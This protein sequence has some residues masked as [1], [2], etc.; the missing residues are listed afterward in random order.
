MKYGNHQKVENG[1][2]RKLPGYGFRWMSRFLK[3][4]LVAKDSPLV[5]GLSTAFTKITGRV[6]PVIGGVQSDQGLVMTYGNIP[7][8]LFGCGRRG[9]PGASHQPNEFIE[10]KT[11]QEVYETV[12]KFVK[13]S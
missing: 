12:L 9:L 8:V 10:E 1:F 2:E 7:C 13:I 11:L 5:C 3:P 6:A 4:A